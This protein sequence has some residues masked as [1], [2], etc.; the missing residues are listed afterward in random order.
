LEHAHSIRRRTTADENIPSQ[1]VSMFARTFPLAG[2]A[3]A[4]LAATPAPAQKAAKLNW[5]PA[6]AVFPAG[7]KMA[8]VSG[9]PAKSG[10]FA[11]QLSMPKG[12]RIAPHYHPTDETVT[13]RKGVFAYGMGDRV[14]KKAMTTMTKGQSGTL[15][16]NMHHY[17]QARKNAVVEVS[18]TGPFAMTYVNPA[19]DPSKPRP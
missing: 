4:L 17:A 15:K 3:F 14:D 13:V 11:I 1:E 19:D 18:S 12:Y 2:V 16:A 8:V 7:A 10:P 5:G 6:P 9:D